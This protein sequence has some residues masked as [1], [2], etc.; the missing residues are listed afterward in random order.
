MNSGRNDI[1][2]AKVGLDNENMYFYAE[3]TNMLTS[4]S[5]LQWMLLFI[6]A[7]KDINTGWEGYDY[8]VNNNVKSKK[9]TSLQKWDGKKWDKNVNVKYRAKVNK[10]EISILLNLLKLEGNNM[11][12]YFK[13]AYNTGQLNNATSFFMNGDTAPDRRFKYHFKNE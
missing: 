4:S 9:I 8:L 3:T 11:N 12:F 13:W 10:L 7:D 5:D 2:K 6:D 1:I